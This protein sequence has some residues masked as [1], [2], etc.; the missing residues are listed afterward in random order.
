MSED[1]TYHPEEYE[2][3]QKEERPVFVSRLFRYDHLSH[4]IPLGAIVEVNVKIYSDC[5][6]VGTE[7][8]LTGR[9][10]LM[11]VK[12]HRDCDGTPLYVLSDI[13]VVSPEMKDGDIFGKYKIFSKY[14][15]SGYSEE[16]LTFT[17]EVKKLYNNLHDWAYDVYG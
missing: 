6:S 4:K 12:H 11:V 7:L 17:G 16:S 2:N 13:P 9:C 10:K 3:A 15:G 8:K 14:F 1:Y 5:P